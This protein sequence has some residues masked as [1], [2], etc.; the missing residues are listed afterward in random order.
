MDAHNLWMNE[1]FVKCQW[2]CRSLP[3][4]SPQS[5][6]KWVLS[7]LD[8]LRRLYFYTCAYDAEVALVSNFGKHCSSPLVRRSCGDL[9]RVRA[10]ANLWYFGRWSQDCKIYIAFILLFHNASVLVKKLAV[11]SQVGITWSPDSK[12]LITVPEFG[13]FSNVWN[14]LKDPTIELHLPGP[15]GNPEDALSFSPD[16]SL[17]A[18]LTKSQRQFF[19]MIYAF[20]STRH[21]ESLEA[22]QQKQ[23]TTWE[24]VSSFQPRVQKP[25]SLFWSPDA[26]R[27]AIVNDNIKFGISFHFL[28]GSIIS[29]IRV[30]TVFGPLSPMPSLKVFSSMQC[31]SPLR[32]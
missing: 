30:S 20:D 19:V 17:L 3:R 25:V 29:D 15:T 6:L 23:V 27:L 2:L 13:L 31:R 16:S 32:Y 11:Y 28:D 26:G 1:Y 5:Q 7:P 14:V 4:L 21:G 18:V 12:F 10:W 9:L 22:S 8:I 24:L